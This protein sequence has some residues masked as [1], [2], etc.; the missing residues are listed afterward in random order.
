MYNSKKAVNKELPITAT[1]NNFDAI[2][3]LNKAK[4]L[5]TPQGNPKERKKNT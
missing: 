3:N 4:S 1:E 5:L 2:C